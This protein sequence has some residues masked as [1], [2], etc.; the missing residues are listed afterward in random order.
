MS[1]PTQGRIRLSDWDRVSRGLYLPPDLDDPLLAWRLLLPESGA[2]THL[3]AAKAYGW[4]LPPLPPGVPVFACQ[5]ATDPRRRRPGLRISRLSQPFERA[6]VNGYF[7]ASSGETLLACARDL[8]LIDMVVLT[9]AALRQRPGSRQSVDALAS[10]GRPGS[11][12]LR[13][14]LA[15]SDPR[16]E[17]P[18]E[19]VLRLLHVAC[20]VPVVRQYEL[21]GRNGVVVARA[22][23]WVVGTNAIHEYDG[24]DH[25]TRAGQQR[26]LARSRRLTEL[27]V[28]RRGYTSREIRGHAHQILRDADLSLGRAHKPERVRAWH[29]WWEDSLFSREGTRR[30]LDR[31]ARKS[32][33]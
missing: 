29:R 11:P 14:A 28:V 31:L 33:H 27:D 10:S 13:Q 4:W 2:F 8:G 22:D 12:M 3:T 5:A 19:T 1:E 23:L 18:W 24:A 7:L 20:G 17:S 9:D 30:F 16:S 32:G 25:L 21:V 6:S 15:H 26:D